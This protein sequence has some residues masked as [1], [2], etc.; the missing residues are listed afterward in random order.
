MHIYGSEDNGETWRVAYTFPPSTIRHVHGITYD[1]YDDCFWICAGDHGSEAMLLRA[2]ADF[3]HVECVLCGGQE[4]RFYSMTVTP[5]YL[6]MANDSPSADNY[7]WKMDKKTHLASK[8]MRIENSS[9]HSCL[10]GDLHFGSTNAEQPDRHV[11]T[12]LPIRNDSTATHVW[13]NH[14]VDYVF[15][16]TDG[17]DSIMH[18]FNFLVYFFLMVRIHSKN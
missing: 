11:P 16:L 2:D 13:M 17:V 1:E 7:L 14:N 15:P 8:V 4:N 3:G 10:V 5:Q 9:S 12:R 18:S 6:Y